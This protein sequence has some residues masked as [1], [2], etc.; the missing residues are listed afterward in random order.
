MTE[1]QTDANIDV[2]PSVTPD[3]P[4]DSSSVDTS[5]EVSTTGATEASPP[6]TLQEAVTAELEKG[7]DAPSDADVPPEEVTPA[8]EKDEEL[9]F[10]EHPRWKERQEELERLRPLADRAKA[11]DEYASK[12]G[13]T[14]D[15]VSAALEMAALWN[16]NPEEVKTKL[17]SMLQARGLSDK[18]PEDLQKRV[19]DGVDSVETARELAK[20]RA[21]A[22]MTRQQA[23]QVA[24]QRTQSD[25]DNALN[26]WE[27]KKK[28]SDP[29]WGRKYSFIEARFNS[30]VRS[31]QPR[32]PQEFVALA[33]KAHESVSTELASFVP[34]PKT[35]VSPKNHGSS[36]TNSKPSSML[37]AVQQVLA[38]R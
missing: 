8:P 25:R 5:P 21:E 2:T 33:E 29:D 24:L 18:L 12:Y 31:Q 27:S 30:L 7:A 20:V 1:N 19:D 10:H 35:A 15:Q 14:Q 38:G 34:K 16:T 22:N 37:E 36:R 4:T 23:E 32:S 9:P 28:E 13:V 17:E 6:S 11:I 3:A 26:A